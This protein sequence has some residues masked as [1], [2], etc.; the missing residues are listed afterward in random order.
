MAG[1]VPLDRGDAVVAVADRDQATGTVVAEGRDDDACGGVDRPEV[2][3]GGVEDVH[4][5]AV[6]DDVAVGPFLGEL[7]ADPHDLVTAEAATEEHV[8]VLVHGD[9]LDGAEVDAAG[10]SAGCRRWSIRTA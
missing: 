3:T 6:G 4:L 8:A 2:A 7:A 1:A 5:G 9:R 10:R